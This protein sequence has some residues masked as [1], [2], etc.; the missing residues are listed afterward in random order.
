M[1]LEASICLQLQEWLEREKTLWKQKVRTKWH[2]LAELNT[3]F[4]H[5]SIVIKMRRNSIDFIKN[6]EG[7][8]ISRR[9]S[10]GKCFEQFYRSLFSSSHP[11]ILNDL[12]ELIS[13][14][15]SDDDREMLGT[16][17][18]PEEIREVVFSMGSNKAP[19]PDGMSALF[20]KFY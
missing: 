4:F 20:Y 2:T 3:R 14:Y 18:S 5:L 16:I 15:L 10:I 19:S 12:D 11:S 6:D 9:D 17:P 1:K 8:W 13:P 7:H